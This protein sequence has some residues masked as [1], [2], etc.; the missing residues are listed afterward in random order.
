MR[1]VGFQRRVSDRQKYS[2]KMENRKGFE[3]VLL[4]LAVPLSFPYTWVF[5]TYNVYFRY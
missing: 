4:I 5:L 2:E 1:L 3:A